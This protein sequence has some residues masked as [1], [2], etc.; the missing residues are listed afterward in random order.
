MSD[1]RGSDYLFSGLMGGG[2]RILD[3][4]EKRQE[5]EKS[6][7]QEYKALQSM[8]ESMGLLTKDQAIVMD[9]PSL[10]GFVK[11]SIYQDEFSQ[12]NQKL[13]ME[14]MEA[15]RRFSA[16]QSMAGFAGAY[17]DAQ[18]LN[19]ALGDYY[20]NPTGPRPDN[21][22]AA[23][24]T[25]LQQFPGAAAD[26]RFSGFIGAADRLRPEVPKSGTLAGDINFLKDRFGLDEPT[27]KQ[28]AVDA[29]ASR[30]RGQN[31]TTRVNPDGSVEIIEGG[32]GPTT[33]TKSDA[34]QSIKDTRKTLDLID[35]LTANLRWNDV[36]APG[37]FG[38][39]V[40]DKFLPMVG[41]GKP[42]A[43]RTDNRTKLKLFI[44]GSL[45]QV[46]PDNRFTNE[47]RQRIENMM[48]S[49]GWVENEEHAKAV[50]ATIQRV[51][52]ARNIRDMQ[53]LG[54]PPKVADLTDAEVAAAMD[55]GLISK[56]EALAEMSK[57]FSAKGK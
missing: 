37:V 28:F 5:K 35:D 30:G 34:Q 24:S 27:L 22:M 16:D 21:S 1:F 44:Q 42:D 46:T 17:N 50:L 57:R 39:H 6:E 55:E 10:R 11:G 7:A 45:R 13:Q 36:G 26:E 23:F 53:A 52:A 32:E 18:A 14:Q 4:L 38:E 15:M 20:E 12:R 51:F 48:P 2:N 31:R 3:A 41:V 8:A 29:M 9:L 25:A 40:L 56:D 19:P 47:D 43:K 33:S 54:Q 49:D